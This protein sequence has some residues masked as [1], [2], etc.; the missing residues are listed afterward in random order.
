VEPHLALQIVERVGRT[1]LRAA[2]RKRG[3]AGLDARPE[4]EYDRDAPAAEDEAEDAPPPPPP[5]YGSSGDDTDDAYADAP[6]I[7]WAETSSPQAPQAWGGG[8]GIH[9][10]NIGM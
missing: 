8:G 10:M 3:D 1:A 2:S 9:M 7:E 6:E 4:G 5:G